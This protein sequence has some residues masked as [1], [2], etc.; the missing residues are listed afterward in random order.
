MRDPPLLQQEPGLLVQGH[1][2][3]VSL[4]GQPYLGQQLAQF[5]LQ[6]SDG[7]GRFPRPRV[8]RPALHEVPEGAEREDDVQVEQ[9]CPGQ[10]DD[11]VGVVRREPDQ[12][13][14]GVQVASHV[15]EVIVDVH[16]VSQHLGPVGMVAIKILQDQSG[17]GQAAGPAQLFRLSQPVQQVSGQPRDRDGPATLA[18]ALL[19]LLCHGFCSLREAGAS[20]CYAHHATPRDEGQPPRPHD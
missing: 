13:L 1:Q 16:Q 20:T 12:A 8:V 19:R 11:Q 3:H 9:V 4:A 10:A 15:L 2:L 17:L 14:A 18:V 7:P 5:R 6:V